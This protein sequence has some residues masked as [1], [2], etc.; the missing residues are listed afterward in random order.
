MINVKNQNGAIIQVCV[1]EPVEGDGE[2]IIYGV[3]GDGRRTTLGIYST[4]DQMLEIM[5]MLTQLTDAFEMPQ[6]EEDTVG[7]FTETDF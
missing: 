7:S 2:Y 5:D 6:N 4:E 1:I 3:L